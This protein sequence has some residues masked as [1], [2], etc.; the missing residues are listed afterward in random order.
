MGGRSNHYSR[1]WNAT[2]QGRVRQCITLYNSILIN[3]RNSAPINPNTGGACVVS[4]DISWWC[5]WSYNSKLI[6]LLQKICTPN[7]SVKCFFDKIVSFKAILFLVSVLLRSV[8]K[9]MIIQDFRETSWPIRQ[10]VGLAIRRS[11][12]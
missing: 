10:R 1:P 3:N 4:F 5:V 6:F 9:A 8:K 7:S 2:R 11:Q 12:V